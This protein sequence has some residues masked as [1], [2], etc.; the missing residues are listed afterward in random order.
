MK[1]M[2]KSAK[3][4]MVIIL[5]VAASIG[6]VGCAWIQSKV[7]DIKG[8]LIG[9]SFTISQYDN[10]GVNF[11]T[12]EGKRVDVCGITVE[13]PS[14][15]S[16]GTTETAYELSSVLDITVDGSNMKTTGNTVIFVEKGLKRIDDFELP[17]Y[18]ESS[19]GTI[20]SIDRNINKLQ[21]IAGNSKIIVISSQLG[22]PIEVYGGDD[23]YTEIPSD[24]PKM[25]KLNI[26][27]KALYVHR[28]NYV[29][30]DADLLD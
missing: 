1:S 8:R 3:K 7:T 22:V 9:N 24:L 14:V 29:I 2:N 13:V 20:T 6:M 5:I 25:T 11:L 15:N 23:V 21:N 30:L 18:V 26:D 4:L 17:E 16:D 27:G 28:A 10:Y 12:V 19:G